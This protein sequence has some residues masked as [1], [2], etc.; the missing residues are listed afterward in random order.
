[1]PKQAFFESNDNNSEKGLFILVRVTEP[2]GV[3]TRFLDMP[4]VNTGTGE[5]IFNAIDNSFR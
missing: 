4:V 2:A 1:M 5:N 3:A